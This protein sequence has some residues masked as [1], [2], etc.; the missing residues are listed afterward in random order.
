MK[1]ITPEAEKIMVERF[2]KDT[3]IALAT[4]KNGVPYVRNVNAYYEDGVF[5]IITYALSNKIKHIEN[6]PVVAIAGDWFTAHGK[7][8]NLGYFGKKENEMIAEKLKRAFAEWINNGHNNF[9]DE[10]TI[11]LCVELTDGLLLSHGT[12]YEI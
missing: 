4:T 8:I 10:N 9:A 11:I 2:G 12:K 7:G 1:K 3:I 6:N 5:Y